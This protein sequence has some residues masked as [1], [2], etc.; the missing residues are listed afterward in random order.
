MTEQ[1]RRLAVGA[2]FA[3]L[4]L[5]LTQVAPDRFPLG[6]IAQGG[7]FGC[8]AGLLALGLVLTYRTTRV[9]NFAY[10]AM[11]SFAAEVGVFAFLDVGVPWPIAVVL[12]V[13]AGIGA[14]VA[15]ERVMR[16]FVNAPRLVVTVATIGLLQVFVGLQFALPFIGAQYFDRGTLIVTGFRTPLSDINFNV[17]SA[18]FYGNDL[19]AVAIVPAVLLGLSWFLLRTEAGTAVRAIAEN[20]ERAMLL[21][22]PVHRLS[23]LVWMIVGGVAAVIMV[24]NAPTNG[25][26]V[27]PFVSTGGVFMPALAAAVV[28]KM[29]SLPVAFGAGLAL[30]IIDKIAFQNFQIQAVGT[31]IFLAVIL[32]ALLLRRWDTSR[33]EVA[34]ESSLSL[35]SA[36]RE[37]PIAVAR[38]P[39]VVYGRRGLLALVGLVAIVLPFWLGPG[40]THKVSGYVIYGIVVL[41]VVV[42]SGWAG[43]ISLGQ[44]AIVGVGA[45][46]GGN[47][48][49]KLNVD[50]F[51]GLLIGAVAGAAC[52]LLLAL[53]ALRVKA[54]YV[55]VTSVAFAAA[56][57]QFFLNPTNYPDAI[58]SDIGRPNLLKRFPLH[59]ERTMYFLCVGFLVLTIVIVRSLRAGRPGRVLLASRDNPR[60]AQAMAV[61]VTKVRLTGMVISGIIAGVAGVLFAVLERGVGFASFPVQFSI[62]AFS[63]AV[64]GGLGSI[65]GALCGV[66]VTQVLLNVMAIV[67]DQQ[68]AASLASGALLLGV[69]LVLPGGVGQAL[70]SVRD[71]IVKVLAARRGIQFEVGAAAGSLAQARS[72]EAEGADEITTERQLIGPGH[73]NGAEL[74]LSCRDVTA[75]YGSLQV[76]FGVD[77]E[78]GD[79]EIVALLGTNGA[80]KSTVFRAITGL[81]AATGG[82]VTIAGQ[83]V[84]GKEPFE[85]A[86][87]GLS[88]MPGGRGIF[89]TLTVAENLR[90]ACWQLRDDRSRAAAAREEMMELFPILRERQGQMAGN[91]SG[92]EQQ[93]LSLAMAFVTKPR[94]LFIDELSLGL[95][96]TIVGQLCDKVHEI[97]ATG[98][99]IVVVEQSVNVAL[100]LAKRA[101]F[102][103]KGRVRFEGPTAGLLERPDILRSVFIGGGARPSVAAGNGAV[104]EERNDRGVALSCSGIVKRF[105][106]ITAINHADLVVP[107]GRIVGLIGHNGAGK[108]TLFDVIS[109]FLTPDEGVVRFAGQDI[110]ELPPHKR[111]ALGLGRSFQEA[112]LFPSL[113]V[114]E[115]VVVALERHLACRDPLAA[116][117]ALPA[118][119]DS[120]AAAYERAYEVIDLLGLGG[121][122]DTPNG[123]LS[124]GTR[125][126][127]E[128]AC[129]LAQ[130]PAILLL[131]E[132]SAGVAQKETEALGPLLKQIQRETGCAICIIEHDMGLMASLCDELVALDL[133]AVIATGS[134]ADVLAHPAVIESYLGTDPAAI[135]RS[136][137][138]PQP[139]DGRTAR[140]R[141]RTPLRA[142]G[143][144]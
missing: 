6:F 39:E 43:T 126:I 91:L 119:V 59:N 132:P 67:S 24:L 77:L 4:L 26:P 108:T 13:A 49:A 141:R 32:T 110:T 9:I 131:D 35:A 10:G 85:I 109:G 63:M 23:R 97:H 52:A 142:V 18:L 54:L 60:A 2:S 31:V 58:P 15:V 102:L 120:D 98:T 42:L 140:A 72:L 25:L 135:Q 1:N 137:D 74:I 16:R 99:T 64:V 62:L 104:V 69:L 36:A 106:G 51:I 8:E 116:A 79:G 138:R 61:P 121:F 107:P 130:D 88:M 127:V 7:V 125:R 114:A 89:P 29:E 101:V 41:S 71:R 118:S 12:A 87:M 143:R 128:L 68:G 93:Q 136:G 134:P 80:G 3:A 112:T 19:L 103:E 92:G 82:D 75:S 124:T 28:A 90:L 48:I 113:T 27:S 56:M 129:V 14:G 34:G 144:V 44:F 83:S 22:I 115:T 78:V 65:S 81:L 46:A 11:G 133:G 21:G 30:G 123:D 53:P 40:D 122:A 84:K 95:A 86:T 96:P 105:G 111:A 76:L 57:D 139:G 117:F 5:I 33:A 73:S 70:E 94:I 45:V 17:G 50:L 47:V 37:L 55:A 20:P 38:L 66:A 100:L